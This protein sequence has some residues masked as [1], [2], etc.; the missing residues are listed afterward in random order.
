MGTELLDD[1]QSGPLEGDLLY[2]EAG[3]VHSCVG[4][5]SRQ[6]VAGSRYIDQCN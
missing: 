5:P 3:F 6:P 4:K 2:Q 1:L